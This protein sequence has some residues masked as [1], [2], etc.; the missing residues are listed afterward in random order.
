MFRSSNRIL[1]QVPW[2]IPADAN[3]AIS[4]TIWEQLACTYT[5]TSWDPEFSSDRSW[6]TSMLIIFQTVS[7]LCKPI[8]PLK[9]STMAQGFFTIHLLDHLKRFASRSA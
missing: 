2:L 3:A 8:V 6:P 9:Q 7:P 4:S 5:A 1:W